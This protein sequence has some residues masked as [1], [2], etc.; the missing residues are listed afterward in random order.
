MGGDEMDEDTHTLA[1]AYALDA[2]DPEERRRFEAHYPDCETCR[3][4]VE[5]YRRTAARLGALAPAPLPEDLRARVLDEVGR[6]RQ[7]PPAVAPRHAD[8]TAPRPGAPRWVRP[9][10]AVAAVVAALALAGGLFAWR[11][12]GGAPGQTELAQVLG[13]SDATTVRLQGAA[14]TLRVVYSEDMGKAMVV[15]S[16]LPDPGDGRTYQ[17]WSV[18]GDT[19]RSAGIFDPS[20]SGSVDQAVE[21]PDDDV[22]LWGVTNEPA[23]GSPEATSD[24]VFRSGSA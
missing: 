9:V 22:D 24:M 6:T 4:E 20:G 3:A 8:P 17:L 1:A 16:D 12:D 19:V 13:A 11:S 21:L 15:G 5:G 2:L 23:G 14:G 7:L 10:L 18:S